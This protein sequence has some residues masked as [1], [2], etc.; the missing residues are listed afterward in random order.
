ML[1]PLVQDMLN[2]SAQSLW[3][4]YPKDYEYIRVIA[5]GRWKHI[6]I[7]ERKLKNSQN[8]MRMYVGT[9]EV[10]WLIVINSSISKEE[11]YFALIHEL[12]HCFLDEVRLLNKSKDDE[13]VIQ[14]ME[15]VFR[16]S[17]EKF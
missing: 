11:K 2:V 8:A 13:R 3:M 1:L 15:K 5:E 4:R 9:P 17:T 16:K 12:G 7:E 14:T 6:K 10:F